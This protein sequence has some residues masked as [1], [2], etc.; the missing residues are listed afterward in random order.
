M[1]NIV[2][3]LSNHAYHNE[4]PYSEYLSSSLLKQY[5]ISPLAYKYAV[6]HPQGQTDAMRFGSLFHEC[7]EHC[8]NGGTPLSWSLGIPLF[9]PPINEKTGQ[10][11]GSSTRAYKEA[12][13]EFLKKCVGKNVSTKDEV[14]HVFEMAT[15]LLYNSGATSQ[16]ILKLLRIGKPEVSVFYET[17]NGTKLKVRPDLITKTKIIDWKTCN[18]DDLSEETINRTISKYGYDISASMYQWVL[19]QVTG[20]WYD[21]F[22]VFVTKSYPIDVVMVDMRYWGYD[23]D[24]ENDIVMPN[25]GARRFQNLLKLHEKCVKEQCWEG[26]QSRVEPDGAGNRVMCP[27]PPQWEETR[28]YDT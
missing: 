10:S 9:E 24:R 13:D 23:Y 25:I 17:E 6:G 2:Y 27:M 5:R 16:Q 28:E 21:F 20:K 4:Q 19:K 8:A 12:Y 18:A 3:G 26:A 7:M 15:Q 11:Y 1:D 22:L 14:A